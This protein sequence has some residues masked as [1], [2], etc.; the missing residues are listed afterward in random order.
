[1]SFRGTEG[2]G[3][4]GPMV[5]INLRCAEGVDLDSLEITRFD[6]ASL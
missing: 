5:V 1:M 3:P 4:K 6:G 2:Q